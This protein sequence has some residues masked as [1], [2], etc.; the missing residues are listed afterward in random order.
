MNTEQ[1]LTRFVPRVPSQPWS[2]P[3]YDEIAR[4]SMPPRMFCMISRGVEEG[5]C[6]CLTEQGTKYTLGL[7]QCRA[8][9]ING[10]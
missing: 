8:V 3:L 7:E 4:P 10:L 6:W 5:T 9:A 1:C 2:A